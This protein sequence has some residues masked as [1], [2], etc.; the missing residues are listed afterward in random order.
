MSTEPVEG[1]G[2]VAVTDRQLFDNSVEPATPEPAAPAEPQAAAEPSAPTEPAPAIQ[3]RDEQ[4]RFT[5]KAPA[6]PA[7]PEAPKAPQAPAP[8]PADHRVPLRELLDERERRQRI[9]AE[10]AQMRNAW[11]QMMWQ[12]QQAAAAAQAQQMPQTIFDNPDFYLRENVINP[13]LQQGRMEFL[14]MKDEWSREMAE[15]QP[16]G[17]Q[18]VSAALSDLG[19]IR[20]TPH[21]QYVFEQIMSSRHPYGALVKWHNQ[22]RMQQQIGPDPRAWLQKQQEQWMNDPKVRAEMVKRIQADQQN[23]G[24]GRP[25]TVNL[26]PSL[27][28]MPGASAGRDEQG[29]L[30]DA[31]L[32]SFATR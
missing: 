1:G 28:S 22:A 25:P 24:S 15:S 8:P 23:G 7:A 13:I 10:A 19:K 16:G 14:R 12:Q 32:Y 26:P 5:G 27:S 20:Q 18:A 2:E 3:G 11:Q 30:S 17:E 4:G 6:P 29:D 21:G 31:S 9:E